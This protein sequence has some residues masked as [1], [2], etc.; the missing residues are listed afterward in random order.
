VGSCLRR[1]GAVAARAAVRADASGRPF[2]SDNGNR[3]IDVAPA[4]PLADRDAARAFD[5][6]LRAIAGVVDTGLLIGIAGIVLVG[7][8]DGRVDTRRRPD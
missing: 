1:L 2:V 5:A 3:V 7:H 8:P 6:A 4:A